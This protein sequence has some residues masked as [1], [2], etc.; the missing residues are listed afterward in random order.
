MAI[1]IEFNLKTKTKNLIHMRTMKIF[2]YLAFILALPLLMVSCGDDDNMDG[3]DDN[4]PGSIA[5]LASAS[6]DLNTLV[7]ALSQAGL[8]ETFSDPT[9]DFTVFAPTDD[10]FAAAGID[11][12]TIDNTTLTA[13][14]QYHVLT[15][16]VL[17]TELSN[18]DVTTLNGAAVTVDLTDGVKI[19]D[20]TVTQADIEASNGVIHI[21][22]KVL[23]PPTEDNSIAGLAQ[24]TEDLSI[25]V[26]ALIKAE[27]V[28]TLSG[29][30]DFTV[31]APTNQAFIDAG[32]DLDAVSVED[33]TNILLYHVLADPVTSDQLSNSFVET[34]N[35]T[36]VEVN[37]DGGVSINDASVA[38]PDIAADNGVIHIIDKVLLPPSG[39]IVDIAIDASTAS[40]PEFTALVGAI[41]KVTEDPDLADLVSVLS[42]EDGDFTVFAPTDAAFNNLLDFLGASSLDDVDAALLQD[43]LLYHVVAGDRVFSTDLESGELETALADQLLVLDAG[44]LSLAD[45]GTLADANIQTAAVNIQGT[46]GVIHAIDKV[47]LPA[48]SIMDL[49]NFNAEFSTLK[50]ALETS[51]LTETLADLEK[52]YTVFAPT[53]DAFADYLDLANISAADLLASPAL[54][55]ILLYHVVTGS[56]FSDEL[57]N[58]FVTTVNGQAVEIDLSSG[59]AVR[60]VSAATTDASVAIADL[61]AGNGVVHIIDQ[62]LIPETDDNIVDVA[63]GNDDL[64]TLVSLLS[65][66]PDLV[67][68]LTDEAGN[69]TVFAPT[70]AAFDEISNITAT[71]TSDQ[72]KEVLQY[73]V[74]DSR[75]YSSDLSDGQSPEMLNGETITINI[76]GSVTITDKSEA[77][78][79]ATVTATDVQT[80]TG[81][82]HIIDK[83]IIPEL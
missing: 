20:A 73:H 31:F 10:A 67:E 4:A 79:D 24:A 3:G 78:E 49:V 57:S 48:R 35:E 64:S 11:L 54:S 26:D 34:L 69:F 41:T 75:V 6:D 55:D 56:V 42:D 28:E 58:G 62:V 30:D 52:E 39:N 18:G 72:I 68:A 2:L 77:S 45:A 82:V 60:D 59:V 15:S 19:N 65:N 76:D 53:N 22:D 80:I 21:I 81:V 12:N 47:L 23:L 16:S 36:Y 43:V 5:E 13:V 27:L 9:A 25:L 70:N 40:A 32:I 29:S 83:V 17:S 71:L 50:A 37:I 33:L 66:Y 7:A 14:L 44:E 63:S 8:V 51:E 1:V 46:N 61:A 74:I 38:T